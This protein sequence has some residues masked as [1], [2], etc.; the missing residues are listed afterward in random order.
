MES[1]HDIVRMAAVSAAA[2]AATHR[3]AW[4]KN[5]EDR[6]KD[7]KFCGRGL[8]C[9]VVLCR[10]LAYRLTTTCVQPTRRRNFHLSRKSCPRT[11]SSSTLLSADRSPGAHRYRFLVGSVGIGG[12]IFP[13][14]IGCSTL[15]VLWPERRLAVTDHFFYLTRPGSEDITEAIPVSASGCLDT[16]QRVT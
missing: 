16:I 5:Q 8:P 12:L 9:I 13:R 6:Q 11:S 7:G 2:G 1:W 3:A 15:G 10:S 4:A 14:R